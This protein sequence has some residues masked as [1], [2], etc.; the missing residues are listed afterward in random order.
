MTR[1]LPSCLAALIL[2][3]LVTAQP[4]AASEL[5]SLIGRAN[6]L[7]TTGQF[8]DAIGAYSQA[9]E[10]SQTDYIL[11]YKRATAYYSLSRHQPAMQDFDRVLDLTSGNFEKALLMKSRI[12]AR[13][14]DWT[15]ARDALKSYSS[16]VKGDTSAG[17]LLFAVSEGE[18]ADRKAVQNKRA[19]LHQEC[20]DSATEALRTATHSA[21]LRELRAECALEAG[22][23]QQAVGDLIRLTH[24]TA[25][26]TSLFTRIAQLAYFLL[27]PSTQAQTTL[28]Q[29]L[30]FDP[31]SRT[32]A[33]L[34]RKLKKLDKSFA[35]LSTLREA[36]DWRGVVTHVFGSP[37]KD[38]PL[39]TAL[40]AE[41]EAEAAQVEIPASVSPARTSERRKE[42]FRT[43]C[44]AYVK[45]EQAKRAEWWCDELLRFEGNADDVDGLIGRGEAALS[46]EQ[47]EEA[48]RALE[49]AFEASGRSDQDV[50]RRLQKAQ[51]LL[52][53]SRQKDY[54]KVL[55][56]SRDADE[57]TIK[58]AYRRAA[59]SA[60]PDKGGSEDKMAAVNEAYEVLSNPELRQRFD[61]GEDP[62]DPAA[63]GAHGFQQGSH[64]FTQFFQGGGGSFQHGGGGGMPF[65]FHFSG[66][67]RH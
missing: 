41:F 16:R 65:Q 7:L 31:D 45:L 48:V 57:R 49:K 42:I 28:K 46:K 11:Y 66:G 43:M 63:A 56:V 33:A 17:D 21:E 59:K 37:S 1:L 67:G 6:T 14:G 44:Q 24:L 3:A 26:G 61:N 12:Y 19:G 54:Y 50:M 8:N 53:Q 38:G 5:Q 62:N 23:A 58:K 9:I 30:H 25:P 2:S 64:P 47:W 36:N 13:E 40:A 35:T 29:C 39:G 4:D 22:D 34:H 20:V 52:K 55:G 32:C 27:P 60:H 51:R 10:Q 18:V 15:G